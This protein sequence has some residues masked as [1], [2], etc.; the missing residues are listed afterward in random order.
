MKKTLLIIVSFCLSLT[1]FGCRQ[2]DSSNSNNVQTQQQEQLSQ[3]SNA[4][5][6]MPAI[7]NFAEK[8]WMK[9]I[10]EKRD[11]PKMATHTYVLDMQGHYHKICDSLGYG[12][13]YTTQ[14]TNPQRFEYYYS[15]GHYLVGTLPQA[16]PNGLYPPAQADGTWI[17]CLSDDK[18]DVD[19]QYIEDHVAVLTIE[20]L[21][22]AK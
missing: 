5:V 12:L 3:Q 22:L 19:V 15:G 13:P 17:M 4:V 16:D 20:P 6:G 18:K 7:H 11:D 8:N 21:N 2:I 14:F 1:L 10:L 9:M